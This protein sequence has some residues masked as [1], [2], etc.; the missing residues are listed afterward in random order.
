MKLRYLLLSTDFSQRSPLP[1]VP[2]E[3]ASLQEVI[4]IVSAWRSYMIAVIMPGNLLRQGWTT[5][6]AVSHQAVAPS[7]NT[8][9]ARP[10]LFAQDEPPWLPAGHSPRFGRYSA[11]SCQLL[12]PS[13]SILKNKAVPG[14]RSVRSYHTAF[15]L[16]HDYCQRK[17]VW[18]VD[19]SAEWQESSFWKRAR[20]RAL[21]SVLIHDIRMKGNKYSAN[22]VNLR[23]SKLVEG[24]AFAFQELRICIAYLLRGTLPFVIFLNTFAVELSLS[25]RTLKRCS[26][27]S[28]GDWFLL[29]EQLCQTKQKR[30]QDDAVDVEGPHS[31]EI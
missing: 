5:G 29:S 1:Q 6:T 19:R 22:S 25:Q 12:S 21:K 26:Y 13:N 11:V 8:S 18:S 30:N 23:E 3:V 20:W 14:T 7:D 9:K 24:Q 2:T 16:P 31:T 4:L 15:T 17:T 10:G 28:Q 27:E